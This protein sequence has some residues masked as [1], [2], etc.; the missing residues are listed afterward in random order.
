VL[1]PRTGEVELANAGHPPLLL[2]S[3]GEVSVL[4][5]AGRP[6]L[7]VAHGAARTDR[8]T[9]A[10]GD[11]LLAYTD[12]L[13]ERRGVEI[14]VSIERLA[15]AAAGS[16]HSDTLDVW[17]DDLLT[18]VPGTPDDDLTVVALRR[19]TVPMGEPT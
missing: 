2:L 18:A 7:G 12:G 4:P 17:I 1:D 14:D 15:S 10:A 19:L 11:I 8:L 9:L 16:D 5:H 6:L 3:G 13:V